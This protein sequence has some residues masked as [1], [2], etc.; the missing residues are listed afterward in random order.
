MDMLFFMGQA[1]AIGV[2]GYAV[3]HAFAHAPAHGSSILSARANVGEPA[4]PA[5]ADAQRESPVVHFSFVP[6]SVGGA[7]DA[8]TLDVM[9]QSAR[10]DYSAAGVTHP[11][12]NA[13]AGREC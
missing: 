4:L 7:E 5:S 2:I 12:R 1:L 9:T 6:E 13:A 11:S 8:A 3:S 10:A